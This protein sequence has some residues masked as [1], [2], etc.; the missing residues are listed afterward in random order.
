MIKMEKIKEKTKKQKDLEITIQF[1]LARFQFVEELLK[2]YLAHCFMII[3]KELKGKIH[4]GYS[5]EDLEDM[6]YSKC[7]TIFKKYNQNEELIKKLNKLT[8]DRNFCAHKGFLF[9]YGTW[10]NDKNKVEETLIKTMQ[11]SENINACFTELIKE[12]GIVEKINKEN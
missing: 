10:G 4:F 7:L 1:T 9:V 12:L 5:F 3:K 2:T 8:Q 11:A 6:P